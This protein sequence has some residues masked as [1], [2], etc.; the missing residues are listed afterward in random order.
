[1]EAR[2]SVTFSYR[3][4]LHEGYA[5]DSGEALAQVTGY[6]LAGGEGLDL[7]LRADTLPPD[8]EPRDSLCS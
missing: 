1:M 6:S 5:S 7:E 8:T 3:L 4:E 2:V